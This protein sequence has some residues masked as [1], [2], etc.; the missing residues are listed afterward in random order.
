MSEWANRIRKQIQIYAHIA[1]PQRRIKYKHTYTHS[2]QDVARTYLDHRVEGLE[3]QDGEGAYEKEAGDHARDE[4]SA[5]YDSLYLYIWCV[6]FGN[7]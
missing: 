1:N 4:H 2:T 7:D 6:R 5:G 3:V